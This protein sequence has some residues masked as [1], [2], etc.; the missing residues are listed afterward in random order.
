MMA[1]MISTMMG[2]ES[3]GERNLHTLTNCT[4]KSWWAWKPSFA[5]AAY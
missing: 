5:A 4:I 2:Q 1:G 3:I